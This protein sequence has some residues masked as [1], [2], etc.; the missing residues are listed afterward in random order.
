[1]LN[2]SFRLYLTAL[3]VLIILVFVSVV[4]PALAE[5][6]CTDGGL[7]ATFPGYGTAAL[8]TSG[9]QPEVITLRLENTS[10]VATVLP[11]TL[12]IEVSPSVSIEEESI[13]S[14]QSPI[15]IGIATSV[16]ALAPGDARDVSVT[17][18]TPL[19]PT[20]EYTMYV[21]ALF[22]D[23]GTTTFSH[24]SELTRIG[25]LP[26]LVEGVTTNAFSDTELT[27]VGVEDRNG[28]LFIGDAMTVDAALAIRNESSED[29]LRADLTWSVYAGG[30]PSAAHLIE[31]WS[32]EVRLLPERERTFSYQFGVNPDGPESVVTVVAS[33]QHQTTGE[34]WWYQQ[35]IYTGEAIDTPTPVLQSIVST[36]TTV[37]LCYQMATNIG[38]LPPNDQEIVVAVRDANT[39]ADLSQATYSLQD[40][41]FFVSLTAT[42]PRD[43]VALVT[44]VQ[45]EA[46]YTLFRDQVSIPCLL[47][48]ECAAVDATVNVPT[49]FSLQDGPTPTHY[50]L[51][52]LAGVAIVVLLWLM[53]TRHERERKAYQQALKRSVRK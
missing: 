35:H 18:P 17:V 5:A 15:Y 40:S 43:V 32:E 3:P 37:T 45:D 10:A 34:Q 29:S 16:A 14:L 46:T 42:E 13:P 12:V 21:H 51:I 19:I 31:T 2:R 9:N 26:L 33:L 47:G 41:D 28:R 22:G 8:L 24:I 23:V 27:L 39:V 4:T 36:G 53:V 7:R 48:M 49:L 20:G 30:V 11:S 38:L 44:T 50:L 52:S 6:L 25:T 1:M